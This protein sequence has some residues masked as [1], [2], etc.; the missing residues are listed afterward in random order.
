[1]RISGVGSQYS[2]LPEASGVET[3]I[4]LAQRN[5]QNLYEKMA[6]VTGAARLVCVLPS[7]DK[8]TDWVA[9]AATMPRVVAH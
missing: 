5:A 4:E 7:P 3:V 8:V 9:Q 1:M 2:G 6:E